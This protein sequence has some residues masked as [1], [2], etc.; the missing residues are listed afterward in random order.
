MKDETRIIGATKFGK[1]AA[2]NT[3]LAQDPRRMTD[4]Q[5]L[6]ELCSC[7]GSMRRKPTCARCGN[8]DVCGYYKEARRRGLEKA[9]EEERKKEEEEM[10]KPDGCSRQDGRKRGSERKKT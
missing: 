6:R 8:A 3:Y 5:L 4:A 9:K 2:M 1:K 7:G 10:K